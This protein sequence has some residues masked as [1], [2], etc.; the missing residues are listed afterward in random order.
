MDSP[1]LTYPETLYVLDRALEGYEVAYQKCGPM[2]VNDR[3]IG[4]NNQ[5]QTKVWVNEDFA[6]NHPSYPRRRLLST[7][8][9]TK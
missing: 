2:R 1:Q 9:D 7:R 5:G 3:M 8:V 4:F 6:N